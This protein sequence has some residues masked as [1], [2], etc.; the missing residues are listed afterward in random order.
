M[1]SGLLGH[2]HAAPREPRTAVS[3]AL[4]H[5]RD[6]QRLIAG[7]RRLPG[8][9]A[10]ALRIRP[11]LAEAVLARAGTALDAEDVQRLAM[12]SARTAARAERSLGHFRLSTAER[13]AVL[14]D[15]L[16]SLAWWLDTVGVFRACPVP[17]ATRIDDDFGTMVRLKGVPPHRH[18]GSDIV[19]PT[20]SPIVAPFDGYASASRG[21]LGGLEVRLRGDVGYLYNAHLVGYGDLGWV[22]TGDVI[23]Y[24]GS[25]GDATAPHD[26]LEWH[27]W[28]GGAVDPYPLL[29]AACF[30]V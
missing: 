15:E 12:R 7:L 22:E 11:S 5:R 19:A 3:V 26:H 18:Q 8:H 6:L 25:T 14:R 9:R 16:A 23:G 17:D 2:A 10:A 13:I 30:P 28:S 24:V 1:A 20:W 21:H 4:E 29:V 27:P